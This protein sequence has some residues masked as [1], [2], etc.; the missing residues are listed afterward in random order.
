MSDELSAALRELAEHGATPPAVDGAGIRVR[1]T[2]RRRRRTAVVLGT[3]TAALVLLGLA[4]KPALDGQA[5]QPVTPRI[6]AA[7]GTVSPPDPSAPPSPSS[8]APDPVAGTLSLPERTLTVDGRLLPVLSVSDDRS[9]LTGPLTVTAKDT[10]RDLPVDVPGKESG[11]V[12]VP[13][14]V[15]LRDAEGRFLHIGTYTKELDLGAYS[16]ADDWIALGPED[17]KWFYSGVRPG[18]RI[19][20]TTLTTPTAI[21]SDRA[22]AARVERSGAQRSP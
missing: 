17:A 8:S 6:P 12:S 16:A 19:A 20:L 9:G 4:L 13:Y 15:E 7:E 10:T 3:G 18:D 11:K 21:P 22:S 2:R 5:D 1:A 14:V